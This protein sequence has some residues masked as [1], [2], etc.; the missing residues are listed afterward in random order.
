MTTKK[1][2]RVKGFILVFKQQLRWQKGVEL[3]VC[4]KER[5]H[6]SVMINEVGTAVSSSVS[7][8]NREDQGFSPGF[9]LMLSQPGV[10]RA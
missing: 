3:C 6:G 1:L 5:E 7:D 10:H 8:R 2:D 9:K 4:V